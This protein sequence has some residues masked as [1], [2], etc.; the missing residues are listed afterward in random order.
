MAIVCPT[1]LAD[2]PEEYDKQL[3]LATNLTNRIQVDLMDGVF[4]PTKSVDFDHVWWPPVVQV[5]V[6]LMYQ[7]PHDY[8]E[9]LI[10]LKPHM[11]IIHAEV[12]DP[13]RLMHFAAE[14]HKEDIKAG[15]AILADTTVDSVEQVIHS[16]DH[17]LVFGGKLGYFGGQPDLAIANKA[18]EIKEH[19]P[20]VE[21][22]WDGGVSDQNAKYL[23]DKGIDVLNAGGYIQKADD[24]QANYDKIMDIIK[25]I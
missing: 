1:V 10:L 3:K 22:G 15:L 21:I 18:G 8:L 24:P 9:K 23:V 19:H 12:E 13:M 7:N 6:H 16:F 4:A 17:I 25:S 2:N 11:V 5:D 14:L 20:E